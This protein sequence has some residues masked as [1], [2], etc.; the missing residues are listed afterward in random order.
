V[1]FL[2]VFRTERDI[3]RKRLRRAPCH[4]TWN[5]IVTGLP[6][7]AALECGVMTSWYVPALSPLVL[8]VSLLDP[9]TPVWLSDTVPTARRTCHKVAKPPHVPYATI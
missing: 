7:A 1:A 4:F 9:A 3:L 5:V 2:L 8:I 6:A